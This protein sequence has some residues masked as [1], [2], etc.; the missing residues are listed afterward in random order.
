VVS[1]K[2]TGLSVRILASG[3]RVTMMRATI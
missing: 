3:E 2:Q 1:A